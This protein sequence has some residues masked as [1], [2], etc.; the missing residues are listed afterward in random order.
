MLYPLSYEGGGFGLPKP[1]RVDFTRKIRPCLTRLGAMI[2]ASP[3]RLIRH[4][5]CPHRWHHPP[6]AFPQAF[7][8][9]VW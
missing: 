2:R 1:E 6:P 4:L 9:S 5:N 3:P 8:L 7:T